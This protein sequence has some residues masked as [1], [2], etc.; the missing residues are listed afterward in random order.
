MELVQKFREGV[1]TQIIRI[2]KLDVDRKYEMLRAERMVTKYGPS[3]LL[4][5]KGDPCKV[6][7]AFMPKGYISVFTDEDINAI[8]TRKVKLHLV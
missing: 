3:V 5:Y 7:K 4:S 2:N 6:V 8:N 1:V